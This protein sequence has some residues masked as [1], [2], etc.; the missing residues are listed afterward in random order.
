MRVGAAA[1]SQCASG[2]RVGRQTAVPGVISRAEA[3]D[4]AMVTERRHPSTAA[5]AVPD[6]RSAAFAACRIAAAAAP[7]RSRPSAS[8]IVRSS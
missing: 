2:L 3:D 5:S 1:R 6:A 4:I 8:K 7:S